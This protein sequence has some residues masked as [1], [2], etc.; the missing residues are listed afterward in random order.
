MFCFEPQNNAGLLP[1]FCSFLQFF[2]YL[3]LYW[4]NLDFS[5]T[6]R[7]WGRVTYQISGFSTLNKATILVFWL[8][9]LEMSFPASAPA[10]FLGKIYNLQDKESRVA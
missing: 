8:L 1:Q 6:Y 7:G 4:P 5:I 9:Y 2:D 10:T 3:H